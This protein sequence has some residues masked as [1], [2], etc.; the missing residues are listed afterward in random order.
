MNKRST[1]L[2]PCENKFLVDEDPIFQRV[3]VKEKPG[4]SIEDCKFHIMYVGFK[5][6]SDGKWQA[7]ATTFPRP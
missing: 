1:H 5:R 4:L 3:P 6:T 7:R 2:Q